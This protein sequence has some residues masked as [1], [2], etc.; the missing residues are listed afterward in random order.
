MNKYGRI[1]AVSKLCYQNAVR[2]KLTIIE[3][4]DAK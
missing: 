3:S 2:D 1:D 4:Y